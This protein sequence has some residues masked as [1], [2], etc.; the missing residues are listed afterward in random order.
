[1]IAKFSTTR[2][3]A[4]VRAASALGQKTAQCVWRYAAL[5]QFPGQ[6]GQKGVP[7][8]LPD[9]AVVVGGID[10]GGFCGAV[11]SANLCVGAKEPS[12]KQGR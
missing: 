4:R 11:T 3:R 5:P 12:W 2:A 7:V 10:L 1:M 8:P 6:A 9:Y